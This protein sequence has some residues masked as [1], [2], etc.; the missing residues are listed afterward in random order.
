MWL[1]KRT[2]AKTAE[3]AAEVG[4]VT[5]E[6]EKLSAYT[7]MEHRGIKVYS[8]GGYFWQPKVEEKLLIIKCGDGEMCAVGE[9]PENAVVEQGEVMIKSDKASIHLKKDGQ[10]M[11]K[12]NV[13]I[14]GSLFVNGVEVP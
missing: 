2:A 4:A 12:G 7:N 11:I 8:P 5:I 1:S 6:G 14:D 9:E 3:A 13:F 10:I